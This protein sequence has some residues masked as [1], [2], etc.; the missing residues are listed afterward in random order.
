MAAHR[1]MGAFG[2]ANACGYL[3]NVAFEGASMSAWRAIVLLVGL[4]AWSTTG[5][6]QTVADG[7]GSWC[8]GWVG[9]NRHRDRAF[10]PG[11]SWSRLRVVS[12][13]R[14]YGISSMATSNWSVEMLSGVPRAIFA[15]TTRWSP[16]FRKHAWWSQSP[17]ESLGLFPELLKSSDVP[18]QLLPTQ[19]TQARTVWQ[20][21]KPM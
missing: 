14:G 5:L 20:V 8:L 21:S 18:G 15:T 11:R 13:A 19:G 17:R 3:R 12:P 7:Q 1:Q 16:S 2:P 6:A 9:R 4:F 10:I